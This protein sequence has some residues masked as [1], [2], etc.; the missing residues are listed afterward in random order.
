MEVKLIG[1]PHEI[2]MIIIFWKK[3]YL[4]WP[5]PPP[6]SQAERSPPLASATAPLAQHAA[7][8]PL[9]KAGAVTPFQGFSKA[10]PQTPLSI[11]QGPPGDAAL[12]LHV[13]LHA[14]IQLHLSFKG[15]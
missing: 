4:G 6:F 14:L 9:F 1:L 3:P 8:P 13:S 10:N 11:P 7:S 12:N 5:L 2:V 15:G